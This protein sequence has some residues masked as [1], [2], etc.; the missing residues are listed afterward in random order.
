MPKRMIWNLKSV[1]TAA[2]KV[3]RQQQLEKEKVNTKPNVY[4]VQYFIS[5]IIRVIK[6]L[7]HSLESLPGQLSQN[8][9]L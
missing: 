9:L 2:E 8:Y 7:C 6:S 4:V 1:L 3:K 5:Y